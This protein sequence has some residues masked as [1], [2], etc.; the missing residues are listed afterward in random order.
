MVIGRTERPD[1][2][3]IR[4]SRA[5]EKHFEY[6]SGETDAKQLADQ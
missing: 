6:N 1:F 5:A 2:E 3:H 4:I